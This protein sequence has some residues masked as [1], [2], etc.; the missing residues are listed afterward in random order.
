MARR[1]LAA[2]P[3]ISRALPSGRGRASPKGTACWMCQGKMPQSV[4]AR[5]ERMPASDKVAQMLENF[6]KALGHPDAKDL[7]TAETFARE[8]LQ[9][10]DTVE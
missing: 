9:K 8:M 5:Y 1:V 3:S 2:L 7:A 4:R 10:A 6:D